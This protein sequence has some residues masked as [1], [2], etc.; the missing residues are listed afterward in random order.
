MII[1]NGTTVFG[2][3]LSGSKAFVND[4]CVLANGNFTTGIASAFDN[5][6]ISNCVIE[7]KGSNVG[8]PAGYDMMGINF[9]FTLAGSQTASG[10]GRL[11]ALLPIF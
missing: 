9:T 10:Q 8:T 2:M 1:S 5:I 6:T 11:Q 3:S 4:T 7:S